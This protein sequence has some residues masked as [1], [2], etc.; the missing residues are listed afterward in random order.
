MLTEISGKEIDETVLP[1]NF[2]LLSDS[3]RLEYEGDFKLP[4]QKYKVIFNPFFNLNATGLD[5][6]R[7]YY[8][9]ANDTF[10]DFQLD[11]RLIYVR[12]S[13]GNVVGFDYVEE[14]RALWFEKMKSSD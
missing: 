1:K 11:V 5:W 6:E 10:Q 3:S 7:D 8:M 14:P 9:I 12:D 4:N 13:I 2:K